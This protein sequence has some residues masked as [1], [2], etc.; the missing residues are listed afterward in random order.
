[1]DS[2]SLQ[3]TD[4]TR[5]FLES[6]LQ[7]AGFTAPDEKAHEDMIN[8]LY[9]RLDYFLTSRIIDAMPP[10]YLDEFTKL[11]EEKRSREEIER[12]MKEKIPNMNDVFKDAF[13]EFRNMY[14][15]NTAVAGNAPGQP[16][17][18]SD[19]S[20]TNNNIQNSVN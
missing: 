5:A 8:E 12:F 17:E 20:N 10:Q 9:S 3:I 18:S 6:L 13:L 19:G 1:M 11:N 7:D 16:D 2:Q 4:E 15:G 14:L